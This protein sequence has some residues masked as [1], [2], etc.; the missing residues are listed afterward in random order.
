M[1]DHLKSDAS[2]LESG[3]ASE[4]RKN[5]FFPNVP[6]GLCVGSNPKGSEMDSIRS[7]TSPLD[8]R[9]FSSLGNPYRSRTSYNE[10][11]HK[12]WD[13]SK[14]GLGI[15][16]SLDDET[17]QI[18]KVLQS[19]LS[20]KVLL[21]P[22]MMIKAQNNGYH[23]DPIQA[24]KSLPKD[25]AIFPRS[26]TKPTNLQKG[27]SAVLFEIG[28]DPFTSEDSK[29][30]ILSC[31]L[32]SPWSGPRLSS[33]GTRKSRF[34][35]SNFCSG[36]QTCTLNSPVQ[37]IKECFEA[38][39]SSGSK[40]GSLQPVT[41]SVTGL[42]GSLSTSEIELSEDYTCVKTHGPNPKIT[43]I[44]CDCV[45][46]CHSNEL[47]DASS[48]NAESTAI[49]PVANNT[50][51]EIL[52]KYP[53]DD[54]LSFCGSCKKKLDGADIYMY[55]GEKAFCSSDCRSLELLIDEE[56][57]EN[58]GDSSDEISNLNSRDDLFESGTFTNM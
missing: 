22:R 45:L 12:T 46:E 50:S 43:H 3:F 49:P 21:N 26:L 2:V 27:K 25:I 52:S 6:R 53:S 36:N 48:N 24:P 11:R 9:V 54:F 18:G 4:N 5:D 51:S 32:D 30:T 34:S 37:S 39:A 20:K 7:P 13:R 15:V 41:N 29:S 44:F 23:I 57:E 17:N 14:V 35:S 10:G 47:S 31:S 1:G 58:N 16:N 42:L 56:I 28:E 8:F 40:P 33:I 55:R 19:S 38:G